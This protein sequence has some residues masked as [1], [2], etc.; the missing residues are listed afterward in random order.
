VELTSSHEA[1]RLFARVRLEWA[2]ATCVLTLRAQSFLEEHLPT[3]TVRVQLRGPAAWAGASQWTVA[4]L[5]PFVTATHD[6]RLN[7]A[8]SGTLLL[9][10]SVLFRVGAAGASRTAAS[11]ATLAVTLTAQLKPPR[12]ALPPD[13]FFQRFHAWHHSCDISGAP[14]SRSVA[15]T[16]VHVRW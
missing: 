10:P 8:A 12:V 16:R 13:V 2:T 4:D 1:L 9:Q 7:I 15:C 14:P 6:L 3:F 11:A 5:P